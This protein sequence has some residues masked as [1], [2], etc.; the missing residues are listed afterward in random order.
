[1]KTPNPVRSFRITFPS[2]VALLAAFC[3]L[4]FS[5]CEKTPEEHARIAKNVRASL[6]ERSA[7]LDKLTDERL[8]ADV[9]KTI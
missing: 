2:A 4:F 7:A 9:V 1:M 5:G 6:K 3:L 8:L